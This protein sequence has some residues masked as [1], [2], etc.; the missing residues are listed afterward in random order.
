[1]LGIRI[2]LH[3]L[4]I[5]HGAPTPGQSWFWDLPDRAVS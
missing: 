2:Y 3:Q 4:L 5:H 1:M